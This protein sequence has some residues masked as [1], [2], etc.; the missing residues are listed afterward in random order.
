MTISPLGP[1]TI[2]PASPD[3]LSVVMEIYDE[4]AGWLHSKGIVYWAYPQP[5]WIWDLV[6]HDIENGCVFLCRTQA[7]GRAVGTLR[8]L[9][10]D[11]AIWPAA[12]D[13]AG[14]IHGL[15]IRLDVRGYGVGAAMLEWAKDYLRSHGKAYLRLDCEAGSPALRQYYEKL[16]FAPCGEI[17]HND[18]VGARYEMGV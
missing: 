1:L 8:I 17:T 13:D 3:E 9:W 7:D 6:K 10:S 15:A 14:Y 4:A 18:Y 12:A 2:N 16:G 11:P 5:P